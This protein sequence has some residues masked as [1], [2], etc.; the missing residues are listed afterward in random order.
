[1]LRRMNASAPPRQ[2]VQLHELLVPHDATDEPVASLILLHGLG[3][4]GRDFVPLVRS[5]ALPGVGPLRCLLP[6]APVRT[7]SVNGESMPA[8]Y[9]ARPPEARPH[10]IQPADEAGLRASQRVVQA[11]IQREVDRGMPA[12]RIVLA[13]FS[14]GAV[15]AL[16]AGVRS[17]LRLAG[18]AV[19]SGYLPLTVRAIQAE[20]H[21]ASQRLPIF[22]A[23]GEADEVISIE[24]GRTART[25][26][27]AMGHAVEW[28]H[29][30]AGH[31][32]NEAQ[33]RAL[34]AWMRRVLATPAD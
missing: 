14:Q 21:P 12:H 23:H 3:T 32:V 27:Q 11:L 9:D 18:L 13:G 10:A 17:P 29:H 22:M 30:P 20:A 1:M 34:G 25:A 15:L 24:R 31:E 28:H 8:W 5:L 19:F 26:L 16:H 2:T 4:D 7:L 33:L 6:H